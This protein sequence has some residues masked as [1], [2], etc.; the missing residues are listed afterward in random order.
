MKNKKIAALLGI[1]LA[2]SMAFSLSACG[3]SNDSA[4]DAKSDTSTSDTTDKS[5]DSSAD[6]SNGAGFEEIQVDEKHSD[7]DVDALTVNAV[8][9]QPIDMEPSGMGLKAADASFHLEAD[10]HAN[11][12]GVNYEI[13][14]NAN[15]ETVGS[16]TF[17]QMNASDGPHYGANVKLD[18]AGSY[19]L[20]LKIE[21]PEKKGWMLHVDPETGVKGRFW[22]EP[23]EVTFPEWNYTPQ[24]W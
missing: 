6:D 24:E 9:F 3:N 7:Q 10:I 22:T 17:M 21:S 1:L 15:N 20:V 23:L 13:I 8:Y 16:G 19:K 5:S 18:E 11:E 14:N 2:G 4:S 12:K